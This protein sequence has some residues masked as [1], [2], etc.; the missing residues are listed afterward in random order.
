[1]GIKIKITPSPPP[2][3][4]KKIFLPKIFFPPATL[5]FPSQDPVPSP[6]LIPMSF[7]PVTDLTESDHRLLRRCID[8][9][10]PDQIFDIHAHLL[11]TRHFA[12]GQP[13]AFLAAN[14]GYG[15][16][17]YQEAMQRRMPGRQVQGLFFGYP[18][19]ENDRPGENA[20]V[21]EQITGTGNVGLVLTAPND[22]RAEV[23]RLLQTGSFIGIKP[24]RL[25]SGLEDSMEATV[26][27]FVPEWM[28]EMC[29]EHQGI[30]MIH[31]MKSGGITDPQNIA[32]LQRLCRRYPACRVVLAHVARSFNYRHAREGLHAI[33]DLP[34]VVVDTSAVTQAGAF[35]AALKIL[36]PQRVLWGSDYPISELRGTC[37]TQGD[38]FTWIFPDAPQDPP[39]SHIGHYTL[40]G[41]ESLLCLRE[42][43]EDTGMTASDIASIFLHNSLR[44]L[45]PH[46]P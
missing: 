24:Y 11:H 17:G 40:I 34:N 27:S 20:W 39:L 30:L 12:K 35:H 28:W 9:F 8:G 15:L 1:M 22:D 23:R 41:I 43:C 5:L 6:R 44:L 13:P 18:S 26:E 3:L 45:A 33:A 4:R 14:T 37:I 38:G 10:L 42:A 7:S 2:N 25:Y 29:D 46:L 36:G 16:A 32:S 31:L 19:A 21:L